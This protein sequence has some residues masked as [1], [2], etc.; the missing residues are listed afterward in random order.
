MAKSNPI[1]ADFRTNLTS[2]GSGDRNY[3]GESCLPINFGLVPGIASGTNA[4]IQIQYNG[5]DSIL[6]QVCVRF[7]CVVF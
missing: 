4:T 1:L 5:G 6:Y 3:P 2:I 7:D